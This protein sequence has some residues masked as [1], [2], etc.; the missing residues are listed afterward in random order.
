VRYPAGSS[1]IRLLAWPLIEAQRRGAV[2]RSVRLVGAVLR[3]P[4]D[5]MRSMLGKGWAE[6]TTILL[7]M[8]R[9]ENFMQ[10]SWRRRLPFLPAGVHA[11][12]DRSRPVPGE[13]PLAH[14]TVRDFASRTNGVAMGSITE[15]VLGAATTAHLIG[16]CP[17]GA[18][19]EDGVVDTQCRVHNYPGLYVI[20]GTVLPANPGINPSLTITAL[21]EYAMSH[22][23]VK[24]GT[25]ASGRRAS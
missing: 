23:P 16:G 5:F 13:I 10:I 19:A 7:V 17:M 2:W 25:T 15:T 24:G 22:F 20:D 9:L 3:H 18:S 21:A 1:F 14:R 8:Q 4:V 12:R 6:R 11:E